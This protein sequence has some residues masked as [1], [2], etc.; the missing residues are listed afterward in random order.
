MLSRR[1]L[2]AGVPLWAVAGCALIPPA[3]APTPIAAP[4]PSVPGHAALYEL[5]TAAKTA[6]DAPLTA[7]QAEL[8]TWVR[9]VLDDQF[10]AVSLATAAPAPSA[11]P[12]S[13][14][15]ASEPLGMLGQALSS[16]ATSFTAQALDR[17]TARPLV[18]ASMAAWSVATG[19]DL[20][21]AQARREPARGVRLPAPQEPAEAIRDAVS[22]AHAARYGLEVAAGAPGL[23]EE[24]QRSLRARLDAWSGLAEALSAGLATATTSPAPAP[25][26]YDVERPA[27]ATAGRALAARVQAA[28]LPILG[29]TIAHGPAEVRPALITALGDAA[30]DVPRWGGLLERWPGL[31][32]T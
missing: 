1:A 8:V 31:P 3:S 16:A 20:P 10:P 21:T 5:A 12:T 6:L 25:P 14:P 7:P 30:A 11:T 2:L 32:A 17:S 27:D 26:W 29:R 15:P 24:E 4:D 18:W 19:A 9:S 13:L 28:A 22:A 23:T